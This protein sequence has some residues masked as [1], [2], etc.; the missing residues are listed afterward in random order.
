MDDDPGE[1]E[2]PAAAA[3]V[4]PA[5]PITEDPVAEEPITED[6]V[7][8]EPITE[9]P[10]TEDPVVE[11][12]PAAQPA[13]EEYSLDA[14]PPPP[15][16]SLVDE[17]EDEEDQEE[18]PFEAPAQQERDRQAE[19]GTETDRELDLIA[20]EQLGWTSRRGVR[21]PLRILRDSLMPGEIVIYLANA[22]FARK[23]S[24]LVATDRRLLVIGKK[25]LAAEWGYADITGA[26]LEKRRIGRPT[27]ALFTI[28]GD[29][30]IDD[31]I[32]NAPEIHDLVAEHIGQTSAGL[33]TRRES[34]AR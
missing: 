29:I 25:G 16:R 17:I 21:R 19:R 5:D 14:E 26:Q 11:E 8:E 15:P 12:P 30:L 6:P 2:R 23:S 13:T 27:I 33:H 32:E 1:W 7:V 28:S 4:A 22:A 20:R 3:P 31:V 10:I 9:D 18:E 24:L 34:E